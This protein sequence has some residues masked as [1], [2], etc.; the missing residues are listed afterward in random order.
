MCFSVS[1]AHLRC[2]PPS[3]TWVLC[4]P[5]YSLLQILGGSFISTG[6]L[7]SKFARYQFRPHFFQHATFRLVQSSSADLSLY[8]MSAAS[9][10]APILPFYETSCMD[11]AEPYVGDH[12]CCSKTRRERCVVVLGWLGDGCKSCAACP[13]VL[14]V[15][16]GVRREVCMSCACNTVASHQAVCSGCQQTSV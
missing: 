4:T 5:V 14:N 12:A 3:L 9:P 7:A 10:E 8:D 11:A 16:V 2:C 13:H 6:Q 15:R 1:Q